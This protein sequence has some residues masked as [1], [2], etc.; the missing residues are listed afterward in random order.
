M[1]GAPVT[2][3]PLARYVQKGEFF[4]GIHAVTD[5]ATGI[6][7]G[8][9]IGTGRP[10]QTCHGSH[11]MWRKQLPRQS[12]VGE[13]AAIGVDSGIEKDRGSAQRE[14]LSRAGG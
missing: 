11:I 5:F 3:R 13:I 7:R 6:G 2:P 1:I 9:D 8:K 14:S 4:P 10:A 12:Y